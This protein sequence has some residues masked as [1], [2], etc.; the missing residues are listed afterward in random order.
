MPVG[1]RPT[2]NPSA[3][4]L[5]TFSLLAEQFLRSPAAKTAEFQ[6]FQVGTFRA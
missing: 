4:N 3:Q 2:A 1:E 5:R 6:A